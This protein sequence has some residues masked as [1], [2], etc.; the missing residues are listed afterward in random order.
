MYTFKTL[1]SKAIIGIIYYMVLQSCNVWRGKNSA[2]DVQIY[3]S[4]P[5]FYKIF[6]DKHSILSC[7]ENNIFVSQSISKHYNILHTT[8]V[9]MRTHTYT[10][11]VH[12]APYTTNVPYIR[13]SLCIYAHSAGWLARVCG[14]TR[15]PTRVFRGIFF[16]CRIN[17]HRTRSRKQ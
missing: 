11:T 12:I 14:N 7:F 8:S 9:K 2:A 4:S 13:F 16:P 1:Q 3:T 10:H 15:P 6:S 5:L 17:H